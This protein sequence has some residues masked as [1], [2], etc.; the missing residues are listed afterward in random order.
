MTVA[1]LPVVESIRNGPNVGLSWC[2]IPAV[3][4]ATGPGAG[5]IAR[6][7]GRLLV[8]LDDEAELASLLRSV[9]YESRVFASNSAVEVEVLR[10]NEGAIVSPFPTEFDVNGEEE[11]EDVVG[12]PS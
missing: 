6:D 7:G 3:K 9:W 2:C 12:S 1:L 11:G 4:E 8:Y 10:C 5:D